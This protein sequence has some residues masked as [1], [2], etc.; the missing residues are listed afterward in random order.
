MDDLL[1]LLV[2]QATEN[3]TNEGEGYERSQNNFTG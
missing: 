1:Q 2:K 3:P